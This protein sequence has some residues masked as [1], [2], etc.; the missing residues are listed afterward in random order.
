VYPEFQP[1]NNRFFAELK[2]WFTLK[3]PHIIGLI[4]FPLP[5]E[6]NLARII[7]EYAE[8]QSLQDCL[9]RVS[10]D[11]RIAKLVLGIGLACNFST[12]KR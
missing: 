2:P 10:C 8:Y 9:V 3:H 4:A 6:D 5:Q 1:N 11:T 12:P 7:T